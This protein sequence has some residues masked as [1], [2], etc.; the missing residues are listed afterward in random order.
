MTNIPILIPIPGPRG[1]PGLMGLPGVGER[2]HIGP[3]GFKG[4]RGKDGIMNF[5]DF[6]SLMPSDNSLII[7]PGSSISFPQN[8]PSNG[9][10]TR[11]NASQFNLLNIGTY[12]IIFQVGISEYGQLCIVLNDFEI[13]S[14]IVSGTFQIIGLSLI[15]TFAI[16][17][18]IS[19]NNYSESTSI[20]NPI[21]N[22]HLIIKQIN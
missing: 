11:M 22:A 9:V 21:N 5:S 2:G 3:P 16:N 18:I 20:T 14:S 1:P 4:E 12:E 15:Q 19:I 7:L 17:S 13:L 8:G 10:I 6:Y